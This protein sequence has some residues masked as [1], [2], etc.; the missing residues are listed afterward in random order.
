MPDI[1]TIGTVISSIKSATDIAKLI[2]DSEI[3][4]SDAETKLRA[5]DLISALADIKLELADVQQQLI[6]RDSRIN[7]LE[8][9]L[10]KRK[11][12]SFDGTFYWSDG[13]DVPFCAVCNERDSKDHHLT[14]LGENSRLESK[15]HCKICN[16]AFVSVLKM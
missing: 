14:F 2:K 15:Y 10:A 13:D 5:A 7:E 8:D 11:R 4:L 6:D 9:L 12:M 3:S 1:A 16:N